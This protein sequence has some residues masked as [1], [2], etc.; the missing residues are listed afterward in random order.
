MMRVCLVRPRA[1]GV[2]ADGVTG[3]AVTSAARA[4]RPRV[5]GVL[6]RA[7]VFLVN[8]LFVMGPLPSCDAPVAP[9]PPRPRGRPVGQRDGRTHRPVRRT[10]QGTHTAMLRT[11]HK[12]SRI[13]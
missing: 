1:G 12:S 5:A 4:V 6:A 3:S 2:S 9:S 10:G 11:R 8:F 7:P 13:L